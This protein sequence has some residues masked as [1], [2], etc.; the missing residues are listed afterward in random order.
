MIERRKVRSRRCSYRRRQEIV[1]M[2]SMID[3][4]LTAC[5]IMHI[6]TRSC[7]LITRLLL[8]IQMEALQLNYKS[9]KAEHNLVI[10]FCV[11]TP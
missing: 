4:V 8:A 2:R 7:A 6:I 5:Y 10:I 3:R 11:S 1:A 9:C